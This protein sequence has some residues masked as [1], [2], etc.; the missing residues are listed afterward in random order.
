MKLWHWAGQVQVIRRSQVRHI[1]T[2]CVFPGCIPPGRG[3]KYMYVSLVEIV[4]LEGCPTYYEEISPHKMKVPRLFIICLKWRGFIVIWKEQCVRK[5][6]PP[7][8]ATQIEIQSL[9]KQFWNSLHR[10]P[11]EWRFININCAAGKVGGTG[12]KW[13]RPGPYGKKIQSKRINGFRCFK[14]CS[15]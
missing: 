13:G 6:K 9:C 8:I 12:I 5:W 10:W 14:R 1:Q 11:S 4:G 3:M 2:N 15:Y 7:V